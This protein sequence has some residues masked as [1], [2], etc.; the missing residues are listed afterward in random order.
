MVPTKPR[1]RNFRKKPKKRFDA[2]NRSERIIKT[3]ERDQFFVR[4]NRTMRYLEVSRPIKIANESFSIFSIFSTREPISSRLSVS[5]HEIISLKL[6]C[7]Q[8]WYFCDVSVPLLWQRGRIP[9]FLSRCRSIVGTR[10]VDSHQRFH[11]GYFCNKEQIRL[12]KQYHRVL[13]SSVESK[14]FGKSF[15]AG[16][17]IRELS[18]TNDECIVNL[19]IKLRWFDSACDTK[20]PHHF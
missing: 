17:I 15:S 20:W 16:T 7:V 11:S 5:V 6:F 14:T 3:D 2:I 9:T 8:M 1:R 4:K 12:K 18:G 10:R 19:S 13:V